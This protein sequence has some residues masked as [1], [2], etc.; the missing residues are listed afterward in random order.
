[1]QPYLAPRMRLR[2]P[3]LARLCT[4]RRK[5]PIIREGRM[6]ASPR[7]ERWVSGDSSHT[8]ALAVLGVRN[9]STAAGSTAL[10]QAHTVANGTTGYS[11]PPGTEAA[12]WDKFRLG[13][14]DWSL[15]PVS[16]QPKALKVLKSLCHTRQDLRN[17]RYPG[18]KS[19]D[20]WW[21]KY[22]DY[23]PLP[24]P[25]DGA[26]KRRAVALDCEMAVI[27]GGGRA[28][29]LLCAVDYLTGEIL[30]N[31]LVHPSKKVLD[32]RTRFSGVTPQAMAAA[33]ALGKTLDGW[34]GARSELWKHVDM[35]TI[36]VGHALHNDLDVLRIIDPRVVDSSILTSNAVG[37]NSRLW[38][39]KSLCAEFLGIDIQS[40]GKLGHDCAED[41]LAAREVVLWCSQNPRELAHWGRI[42]KEREEL[43]TPGKGKK[44]KPEGNKKKGPERER[45][46]RQ[47]RE[48]IN[49]GQTLG[50]G[51]NCKKAGKEE[52]RQ[53]REKKKKHKKDRESKCQTLGMGNNCNKAG[54]EEKRQ[55]REKKGKHKEDKANKRSEIGS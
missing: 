28:V 14:N 10:Q 6:C 26:P 37:L 40:N 5:Y 43:N 38:G 12:G 11:K 39:L 7:S 49:K 15:I 1:M 9:A 44:K 34:K 46:K 20:R 54:K 4:A 13:N 47:I 53:E 23:E 21:A 48:Q 55:E 36:L 19:P 41:A 29:V 30:I 50:M 51:R 32:W 45:E 27:R 24:P 2:S 33:T 52:N 8:R 25:C 17:H 16:R 3:L 18:F 22:R 31:T 42:A 35:D